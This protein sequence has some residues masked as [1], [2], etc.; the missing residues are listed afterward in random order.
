MDLRALASEGT[1]YRAADRTA[2]SVDDSVLALE[3]HVIPPVC[4]GF[5]IDGG[6]RKSS[7]ADWDSRERLL[8]ELGESAGDIVVDECGIPT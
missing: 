4:R 1:S 3:Q 6:D 8:L 2:P 7:V 5:S